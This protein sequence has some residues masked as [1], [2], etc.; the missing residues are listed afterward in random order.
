M[1]DNEYSAC[2]TVSEVIVAVYRLHGLDAVDKLLR[3]TECTREAL[4][5]DADNFEAIG[6][7]QLA[8]VLRQHAR[9]AKRAAPTW[10]Q[11]MRI[12]ERQHF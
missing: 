6:M 9:K 10:E 3:Q 12:K 8:S 1:N 7:K 11:R 2:E 5:R 4:R